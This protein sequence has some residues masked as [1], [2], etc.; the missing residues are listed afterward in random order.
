MTWDR[1]SEFPVSAQTRSE[2]RVRNTLCS[3]K[4]ASPSTSAISEAV[5]GTRLP[6]LISTD[7]LSASATPAE[8]RMRRLLLRHGFGRRRPG[9]QPL[10]LLSGDKNSIAYDINEKGQIVGQ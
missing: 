6:L 9:M 3:G 10:P 4:M 5:H 7:R 1:S 8:M 2:A